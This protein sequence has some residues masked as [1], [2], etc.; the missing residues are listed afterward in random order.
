MIRYAV[1]L[2]SI[3]LAAA[4]AAQTPP[5]K[6]PDRSGGARAEL[7]AEL[8]RPDAPATLDTDADVDDGSEPE[9][10]AEAPPPEPAP[11][12]RAT[13]TVVACNVLLQ[14]GA[15][16]VIGDATL[17]PGVARISSDGEGVTVVWSGARIEGE[18]GQRRAS[19]RAEDSQIISVVLDGEELLDGPQPY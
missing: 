15:A 12:G 13:D 18:S 2:A 6:K 8:N 17:D 19:C 1:V 16:A 5:S 4:S 9:A 7:T 3:C 11:I 10:R 14:A